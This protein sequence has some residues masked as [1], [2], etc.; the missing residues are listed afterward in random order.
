M[1]KLNNVTE[2]N[3]SSD[4]RSFLKELLRSFISKKKQVAPAEV[5]K[6]I[7]FNQ[8]ELG[9]LKTQIKLLT[10]E[11]EVVENALKLIHK[12]KDEDI[13][14]ESEH[15]NL[16]DRYQKE[17]EIIETE[18]NKKRALLEL[19]ELQTTKETVQDSYLRRISQIEERIQELSVTLLSNEK[20]SS[21]LE[22]IQPPTVMD[23]ALHN[24]M[25]NLKNE[26]KI[27]MEKLEQIEVES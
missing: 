19:Q 22:P 2:P 14:D 24:R 8:S 20:P 10:I 4:K 25:V 11:K 26:I 16:N 15:K 27:A 3:H 12:V 17:R 6:N 5:S 21:Y 7:E 1:N 23:E 13:V 18:L 9:V